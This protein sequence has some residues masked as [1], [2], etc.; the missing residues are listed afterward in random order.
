MDNKGLNFSAYDF[1][2]YLIPGALFVLLAD[3]LMSY[4]AAGFSISYADCLL[5][6]SNKEIGL[7]LPFIIISYV[8]GHLLSFASAASVE[9]YAVWVYGH[10]S[11]YLLNLKVTGFWSVG[12]A[13]RP[14]SIALRCMMWFFLFP[15]SFSE[16]LFGF[17]FKLRGNYVAPL[18]KLLIE[19]IRININKLVRK[20]GVENPSSYG[21]ASEHDFSKLAMHYATEFAPN[22]IYTLRNYVALYGF[23]RT[24]CLV[25][26]ILF[27]LVVSK[28]LFMEWQWKSIYGFL[29]PHGQW[30]GLLTIIITTGLF[31]FISFLAFMKFFQRYHE[32]SLFAIAVAATPPTPKN[33]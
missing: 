20:C 3:F 4:Q 8:C 21:E 28:Y 13:N 30:K 19:V 10:P 18:D 17:C 1:L 25:F 7:V 9:R 26:I 5:R 32:E 24:V 15:V 33:S 14:A 12:G 16:F 11:K 23:L 27:W 31:C 2:G 22:H 6:Y 29:I